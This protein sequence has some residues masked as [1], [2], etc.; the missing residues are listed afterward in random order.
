MQLISC[1][2]CD[3]NCSP[4][5]ETCPQCGQPFKKLTSVNHDKCFQCD[6]IATQSCDHCDKLSCPKHLELFTTKRGSYRLCPE[7]GKDHERTR[8]IGLTIAAVIIVFFLIV[9]SQ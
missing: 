4:H 9:S 8:L 3:N 7:C 1:P 5:A 6:S 2:A